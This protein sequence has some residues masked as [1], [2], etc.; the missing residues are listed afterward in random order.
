[1]ATKV[2]QNK[3]SLQR[4]NLVAER[5]LVEILVLKII[6]FILRMCLKPNKKKQ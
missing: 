2:L 6:N 5:I 4:K 3:K 1:M